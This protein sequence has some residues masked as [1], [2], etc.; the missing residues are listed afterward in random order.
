MVKSVKIQETAET[1]DL[2]DSLR[3]S[4]KSTLVDISCFQ[5]F[6]KESE[7]TYWHSVS[8][9]FLYTERKE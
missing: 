7:K 2:W 9:D 3:F 8:C 6:R 1:W 5:I 4:L